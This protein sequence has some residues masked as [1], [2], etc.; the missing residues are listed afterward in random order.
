MKTKSGIRAL[1]LSALALIAF[2]SGCND[3]STPKTVIGSAQK[4]L[5]KSQLKKF[6]KTLTGEAKERYGNLAGMVELQERFRGLDLRIGS[7][8]MIGVRTGFRGW[9]KF[10][11][12]TVDLQSR[13]KG[14]TGL[15]GHE[16]VITVGCDVSFRPHEMRPL[17]SRGSSSTHPYPGPSIGGNGSSELTRFLNET[18]A[19]KYA[20]NN[21][22]PAFYRE[23]T[24][25]RILGLD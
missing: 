24:D 5:E 20:P 13:P 10:R 6:S 16:M 9:D 21:P 17:G 1:S 25:C 2:A 15:Y 11:A 23:L 19:R 12:Y 14:Q 3:Y 18:S 4:A 7:V 8:Q 22:S